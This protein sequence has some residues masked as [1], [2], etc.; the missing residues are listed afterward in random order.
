MADPV[1]DTVAAGGDGDLTIVRYGREQMC[2]RELPNNTGGPVKPGE[3]LMPAVDGEGNP[4]FEYHD[5][6]EETPLFVAEEARGRGMDATTEEG[7]EDGEEVTAQNVS[8]GGVNVYV[9]DGE[10]VTFGQPLVPDAG[11][12]DF[13]VATG[14]WSVAFADETNDLSGASAPALVATEVNI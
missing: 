8:G 2:Q 11:T 6:N 13:I 12:G 5:G 9:S 1:G 10:A 14:S 3:A 7:Y 4:V